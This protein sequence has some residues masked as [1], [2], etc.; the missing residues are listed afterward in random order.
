M[1]NQSLIEDQSIVSEERHLVS[2]RRSD[3]RN[4]DAIMPSEP[5]PTTHVQGRWKQSP[6]VFAMLRQNAMN[7]CGQVREVFDECQQSGAESFICKS[8]MDY[9]SVCLKKGSSHDSHRV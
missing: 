5:L 7:D 4:N 6:V 2:I 9:F 3:S 1:Y 8:A